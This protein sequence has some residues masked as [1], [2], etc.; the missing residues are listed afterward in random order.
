MSELTI[1]RD[2]GVVVFHDKSTKFIDEDRFNA[3]VLAYTNPNIHKV[4]IGQSLYAKTSI[5]KI[6]TLEEYWREYPKAEPP[7]K[8]FEDQFE[9]YESITTR[10]NPKNG[11][12]S[13]IRGLKRFI[14][15]EVSRGNKVPKAQSEMNSQVKKY[16]HLYRNN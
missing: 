11:L 8:K 4:N 7:V 6:L 16:N 12:A 15:E 9:K 14:D 10:A 2:Y 13:M 3:M 1:Q 5:S